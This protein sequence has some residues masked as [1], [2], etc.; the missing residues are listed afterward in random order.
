[1][2]DKR[3]LVIE[4]EAPLRYLLERQ[5][6]RAGYQVIT[7]EDGFTGVAA[8]LAHA[9]DLIVLDLMMPGIDGFEVFRRLRNNSRT[10]AIPVVFLSGSVNAAMRRRAFDMGATDVLAKPH[11]VGELAAVLDGIFRR[12]DQPSG[13]PLRG[14]VVAL[15][16]TESGAS[17]TAMA[18]YLSR[19]VALHTTWPVLLLDLDLT[20]SPV[21]ARLALP[22]SPHIM[23]LLNQAAVPITPEEVTPYAQRQHVGLDVITAP[24]GAGEIDCASLPRLR[25]ALDELRAL[26]Y[27]VVMHLGSEMSD[28]ALSAMRGADLVCALMSP[29]DKADRYGQFVAAVTGRGVEAARITLIAGEA[30]AA[31]GWTRTGLPATLAPARGEPLP[32]KALVQNPRLALDAVL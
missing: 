5:L 32:A 24:H 6:C 20:T 12:Q 1:M 23:E 22:R 26:G 25:A 8:A 29:P 16:A 10:A 30:A 9:P 27:Y 7:A 14:R 18:L 2:T 28:L 17:S 4:D 3:I 21:A 19:M 11:Q 31:D 13:P 15:F